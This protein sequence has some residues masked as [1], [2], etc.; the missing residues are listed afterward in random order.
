[1]RDLAFNGSDL[2]ESAKAISYQACQVDPDGP[3]VSCINPLAKCNPEVREGPLTMVLR[4]TIYVP[5]PPPRAFFDPWSVV[6]AEL[7]SFGLGSAAAELFH[8]VVG[9]LIVGLSV[10]SLAGEPAA[11]SVADASEHQA[12]VGIP[13][14]SDVL[15]PVSPLLSGVDSAGHPRFLVF[16]NVDLYASSSSSFEA[17]G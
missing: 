7:D 12:C 3:F 1:V 13:L 15:V 4:R 17:V 10:V 9:G 14:P 8:A 11:V 2:S 5:F 16:P 6:N